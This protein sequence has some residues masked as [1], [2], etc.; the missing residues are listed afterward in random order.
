MARILLVL[1]MML[2]LLCTAEIY[3]WTD[4][5]G[6]THF[7]DRP[8]DK[9]KAEQ[10]PVEVNVYESVDYPSIAPAP[11]LDANRVVM[12]GASWCGYCRQARNYFQQHGIRYVEYD[13]E[14]NERARRA[15]DS[16]G[17]NGVPV[18]LVGNKRMNGFSVESFEGIY[19]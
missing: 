19:P 7:G 2:P 8:Q 1:M 16:I 11:S 18:I 17:G 5:S 9:E 14:K 13:I 15:Y 6:R 3:Q 4:E 10:V 12:Y